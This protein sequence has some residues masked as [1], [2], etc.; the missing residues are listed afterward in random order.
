[1]LTP[2]GVPRSSAWMATITH[3][4]LARALAWPG[5]KGMRPAHGWARWLRRVPAPSDAR[6]HARARAPPVPLGDAQG[7]LGR[8]AAAP[9]H[10]QA[11]AWALVRTQFALAPGG[12]R[13]RPPRGRVASAAGRR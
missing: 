7:G 9:P 6:A 1:M 12:P 10:I 3:R 8:P 5:R 2:A 11:P 13:S 4:P